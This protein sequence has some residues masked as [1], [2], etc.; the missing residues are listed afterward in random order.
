MYRTTSK[1]GIVATISTHGQILRE[2]RDKASGVDQVYLPFGSDY[3]IKF[4]NLDTRK[5]LIRVYVDGSDAT[6][7]AQ[8]V[9]NPGNDGILEGFLDSKTM[10]VRNSFRF[11]E[12]TERI[13]QHRGDKIEDGLIR[14]EV[15]FEEPSP[16]TKALE[17]Y[18]YFPENP[19]KQDQ[20]PKIPPEYPHVKPYWCD[21]GVTFY[22]HYNPDTM[23]T[24]LVGC[25]IPNV[26]NSLNSATFATMSNKEGITV[27]GAP[28]QQS[29]NEVTVGAKSNEKIVMIFKLMGEKRDTTEV[30]T[31]LTVNT[32]VVCPTCGKHNTS[33]C[34]YCSECGTCLI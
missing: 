12:K 13:S 34:K 22:G 30:S 7:T 8:L 28:I 26:N 2:I 25:V 20:F 21:A 31:P 17:N 19:W 33:N 29:F 18:P 4:K 1:G 11:I 32:K 24:P 16:F 23:Q 6:N 15:E 14:V 3:C 10:Q 9:V 5:A 27:K